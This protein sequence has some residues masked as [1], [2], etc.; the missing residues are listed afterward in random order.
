MM[1]KDHG[2]DSHQYVKFVEDPALLS[3]HLHKV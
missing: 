1:Q 2:E 3:T